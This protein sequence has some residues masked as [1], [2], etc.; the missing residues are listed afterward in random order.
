MCVGSHPSATTVKSKRH[1]GTT[2]HTAPSVETAGTKGSMVTK[3]RMLTTKNADIPENFG[4]YYGHSKQYWYMS[5]LLQAFEGSLGGLHTA[6]TQK[7]RWGER[8]DM[9]R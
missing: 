5:K 3:K 1:V 9:Q 7:L 4:E 6:R 8:R 2:V